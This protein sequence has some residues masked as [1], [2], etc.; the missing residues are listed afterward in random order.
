MYNRSCFR[1]FCDDGASVY[2]HAL[3]NGHVHVPEF[4]CVQRRYL[5]T[6]GNVFSGLLCN[7]GKRS[8]DTVKNIVQNT[9]TQSDG[10]SVTAGGYRF[11]RFQSTGF[12]ENL[13]SS[14][15]F[16][17]GNDLAHQVF[18]SYINH[19]RHLKACIP[20]QVNDRAVNAVNDTGFTH[21]LS[22]RQS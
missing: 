14:G 7:D 16:F 18:L 22:L 11:P 17:Q 12:L 13:Y 6:S 1:H 2:F 5:H 10:N 15:V 21:V 9:G 20:L 8:L 3:C 19:F 4:F